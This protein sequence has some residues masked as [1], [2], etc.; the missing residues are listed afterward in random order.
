MNRKKNK[1]KKINEKNKTKICKTEIIKR[2][3]MSVLGQRTYVTLFRPRVGLGSYWLDST[4]V[5]DFS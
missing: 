3:H 2:N 5:H 4:I 1:Q